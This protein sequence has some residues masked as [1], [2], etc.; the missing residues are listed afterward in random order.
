MKSFVRDVDTPENTCTKSLVRDVDAAESICTKAVVRM[1][2]SVLSVLLV[3]AVIYLSSWGFTAFVRVFDH[4][5]ST[6]VNRRTNIVLIGLSVLASLLIYLKQGNAS[7]TNRLELI[8][9]AY[10]LVVAV[11][12]DIFTH[13][14]YDFNAFL[15]GGMGILRLACMRPSIESLVHLAIFT[16]LQMFFFSRMYGKGDVLAWI[17]CAIYITIG[18]HGLYA[19][20][21]HMLSAVILLAIVQLFRRNVNRRGNLRRPVAFLPYIAGTV[22]LFL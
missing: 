6:A 18:G 2:M 1:A 17:V 20:F 22:W 5:C 12:W 15:V 9:L 3:F 16:V 4:S 14:I 10:Y 13:E 8:L 7:L 19:Y 21:L 11:Y